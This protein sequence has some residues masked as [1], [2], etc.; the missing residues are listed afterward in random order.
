MEY[1][2]LIKLKIFLLIKKFLFKVF[3][4]KICSFGNLCKV[5]WKIE[6]VKIK[7]SI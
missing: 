5:N 3:L 6:K 4:I 2:C 1:N 7:Y